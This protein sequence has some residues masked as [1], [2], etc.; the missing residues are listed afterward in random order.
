MNKKVRVLESF[1]TV[2]TPKPT[3]F[4]K[5][6]ICEVEQSLG[7]FYI[8]HGLF[9]DKTEPTDP[10]PDPGPGPEEGDSAD[11]GNGETNQPQ[12][13]AKRGRKKAE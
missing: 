8:E 9:E 2:K 3:S 7:E 4:S 12:Q 11:G 6:V 1:V 13:P 10:S 5:Q